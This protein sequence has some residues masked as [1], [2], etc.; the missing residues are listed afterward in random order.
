MRFCAILLV[1]GAVLCALAPAVL[2]VVP[3]HIN[4]QGTLTDSGGNGVTG[5]RSLQ[6][7]LYADSVGGTALWNETHSSVTVTDGLFHVSLGSTQSFPDTL[8]NGQDLWLETTVGSET[9]SPREKV[10]TVPYA[11]LSENANNVSWADSSCYAAVSDTASYAFEAS[12]DDDWVLLDNNVYRL[13]GNVGIG[14]PSPAQKLDVDGTAQMTG[15]KMSTGASA[16]Y[17]LTSDASGSGTWQPGLAG[18][19]TTNYLPKYTG[20]LTLGNSAIYQNGS[21]I[22]IGTTVPD[23]DLCVYGSVGTL[24][25]WNPGTGTGYNGLQLGFNSSSSLDAVLW[26]REA[27]VLRFGTN[28]AERMLI[29][30]DGNIGIGTSTPAQKLDVA[31]TIQM[32]GFKMGTGASAGRILT[33]DA[34][35]VGTWQSTSWVSGSGT[36]GYVPQFTGT[37]TLGNSQ[38]YQTGNYVGIGTT[39][40]DVELCLYGQVGTLK[41]W[42]PGTGTGYN[43]LQLGFASNSSLDGVLWNRENGCLEFAT[44]DQARM[45][46]SPEG[47]VGI[48]TTLPSSK[49]QVWGTIYSST[50]GY[51]YPDG[52][53]QTTAGVTGTG[54]T[55][56]LPKYSASTSVGNSLIYQSGSYVGIGTTSP[57]SDLSIYGDVG[58]IR[59][60]NPGT[61]IG[62]NGMSIG[63]IASSSLDASIWNREWGYLKFGTGDIERMRIEYNGNVGIGT[64][65]SQNKLDVAG[66]MAVGQNYAGASTAPPNG[67]IIQGNVGIGITTPQNKLDV[68]GGMAVG[69]G[70]AGGVN[71]PANGMI[72]LGDVGIGTPSPGYKLDVAGSCH[73]TSFPTSSDERLKTNVQQLT[74][75]LDKI[76]R[77]RGVAFDWNS[78]YEAM[79]RSTGHREIGVIAQEVEAQ[80]PELVTTWGD[81]N[82]RAVDYGRLTAVLIEAVKELRTDMQELVSEN[83]DLRNEIKELKESLK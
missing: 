52:T 50:G 28:D 27:G 66:A 49:L 82:Y 1:T 13:T 19:G 69:A 32:T 25:L 42:N 76:D 60:F 14:T 46:I 71:A 56:Y 20:S 33:S 75:V 17:F 7:H 55:G 58:S 78:T 67:M 68:A 10:A 40:P 30:A 43:G 6:F 22:G 11:F 9:L 59:I 47:D 26:N 29:S 54:T 83:E 62:Y 8:F 64:I 21:Y 44:N 23:A 70:F 51:K 53:T 12:P 72:I 16:G 65:S 37:S 48:G 31:G 41:I 15:F 45:Y 74:G 57:S 77:I 18:A 81:E 61:G 35:G 34:S 4:F 5:T 79:G 2:G 39:V 24:K 73:A 36:S 63:Y 80:F 38:I 3:N